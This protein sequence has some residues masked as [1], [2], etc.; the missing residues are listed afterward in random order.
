MTGFGRVLVKRLKE[1]HM[2]QTAF[3]KEIGVDRMTVRGWIHQNRIPLADRFVA[4]CRV[5]DI[6]P[7]AVDWGWKDDAV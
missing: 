4:T 1:L 5:L 2:S 7:M 6:D 3:A